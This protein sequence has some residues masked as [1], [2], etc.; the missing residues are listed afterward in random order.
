M[1]VKIPQAVFEAILAHSD[2]AYPEE[3]CGFLLSDALGIVEA[4]PMANVAERMRHERPEEFTRGAAD[5]YVMDPGEQLRAESDA[6]NR[7]R[8]IVGTYHSHV[9]V[10]AYFSH[11]D[12]AR[13]LQFGEPMFTTYVV[14]DAQQDGT[15]GAKAFVWNGASREFVET[16][17]E[18]V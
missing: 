4:L 8:E 1:S 15:Y 11:E 9:D 14:S 2:R 17:I 3:A 16:P 18:I 5:G 12:A 6:R 10:G 13:A 7:G